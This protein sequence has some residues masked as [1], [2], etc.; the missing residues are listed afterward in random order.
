MSLEPTR[1]LIRH[2]PVLEDGHPGIPVV[3]CC[4][5]A[6][7]KSDDQGFYVPLLVKYEEGGNFGPYD[8][9]QGVHVIEEET[10]L[11]DWPYTVCTLRVRLILNGNEAEPKMFFVRNYVS[12]LRGSLTAVDDDSEGGSSDARLGDVDRSG[13]IREQ[14][15]DKGKGPA[16]RGSSGGDDWDIV[17]NSERDVAGGERG[18]VGSSSGR[19]ERTLETGESSMAKALKVLAETQ[20]LLARRQTDM[21]GKF[22]NLLE[23]VTQAK[24]E[25]KGR[26]LNGDMKARLA[27][28]VY[29]NAT[30]PDDGEEV[31]GMLYAIHHSKSLEDFLGAR[32]ARRKNMTS[33]AASLFLKKYDNWRYDPNAPTLEAKEGF[34]QL[35]FYEALAL[36]FETYEDLFDMRASTLS[37]VTNP[38]ADLGVGRVAPS[39]LSKWEDGVSYYVDIVTAV[40]GTAALGSQA[41][42]SAQ[43]CEI[44]LMLKSATRDSCYSTDDVLLQLI[45]CDREHRNDIANIIGDPWS[46]VTGDPWVDVHRKLKGDLLTAPKSN[47]RTH[48]VKLRNRVI[49]EDRADARMHARLARQ[50][51]RDNSF[52]NIEE[53]SNNGEKKKTGQPTQSKVVLHVEKDGAALTGKKAIRIW[54]T[55]GQKKAAG[56]SNRATCSKVNRL[57]LEGCS[58][59]TCKYNHV[60]VCKPKFMAGAKKSLLTDAEANAAWETYRASNQKTPDAPAVAESGLLVTAKD[61]FKKVGF[62]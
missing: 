36:R 11:P 57:G 23:S 40:L 47:K 2:V 33:A 3:A 38:L 39:R 14:S 31:A 59:P 29:G 4:Y 18:M 56:V 13:Q 17:D 54:L 55:A 30:V 45:S 60:L 41:F 9:A 22:I 27:E 16:A 49:T 21:D 61:V 58:D 34:T 44:Q 15:N 24:S 32:G 42:L 26:R 51:T 12:P 48:F 8:R 46:H 53:I 19:T 7:S 37:D 25:E 1:V 43:A 35:L 28:F 50:F 52:F 62:K 10:R 5:D 20:Q 6:A